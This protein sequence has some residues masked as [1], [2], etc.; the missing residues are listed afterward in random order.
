MKRLRW[1][2][3]FIVSLN[4]LFGRHELPHI[5]QREFEPPPPRKPGIMQ[6]TPFLGTAYVSLPRLRMNASAIFEPK[7]DRF[8]LMRH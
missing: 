3:A 7:Q 1:F 5:E 2:L 4:W 6:P 8:P